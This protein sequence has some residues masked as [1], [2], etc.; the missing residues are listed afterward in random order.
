MPPSP[1]PPSATRSQPSIGAS[2]VTSASAPSASVAW[3]SSVSCKCSTRAASSPAAEK[4]ADEAAGAPR[5]APICRLA[6]AR[7]LNNAS[8]AW[9][10]SARTASATAPSVRS[11]WR[12][13]SEMTRL[14]F[15]PAIATV[16]ATTTWRERCTA[17][18]AA[19]ASGAVMSPAAGHS[20]MVS[21]G[22]C[23]A[24]LNTTRPP[25]TRPELSQ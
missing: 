24:R 19:A 14:W 12:S 20:A 4:S 11:P 9:P 17:A 16:G 18:S 21:A 22:P 15:D 25:V 7:S 6:R 13:G 23:P 10:S 2:S 1:M 3:R 8:T 5:L